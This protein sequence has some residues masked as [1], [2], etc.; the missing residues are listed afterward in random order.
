MRAVFAG[1]GTA[2]HVEPALATA[3]ALARAV[4]DAQITMVGT[5]R[6]LET[7]LVPERGYEL[8]L[9]PPVPMPR[10][11]T[12]DLLRLPLRMRAAV[13]ATVEILRHRRADVVVG[14]GGYVALPAYL[15]ARKL[16][17]PIVIHEANARPGL[18]NRIGARF[19]SHVA[20][21]PSAAPR[22]NQAEVVGIPLRTSISRLDR[23]ASRSEAMDHF[24]LDPGRVTL[25]VFGGSQG[26][27]RLNDGIAGAL[28]ALLDS[29]TQV[30]H[31]VGPAH[32][33]SDGQD[34]AERDGYHRL[35]YID[36]MD[37][38]YA[39]ADLV[40]SRAGAITCAE[41]SAV[42]LPAI[43]VP[44]PHGNGEQRF[45]ALPA[46]E[47]GGG[48]L[49]AD[50]SFTPEWVIEN[51]ASLLRN[52]Q[53][54]AEMGSAAATLGHRDA[55]DR[56]AEMIRRAAHGTEK[57]HRPSYGSGEQGERGGS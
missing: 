49:V 34:D 46:V 4:P 47:A 29:R 44:L 2:G 36:R 43:Y 40:V 33:D 15:A 56:L 23:Q 35:P 8:D 48:H 20:A 17:L 19:T 27:R 7:R 37:L 26:A 28:D 10:R 38:A 22:M 11:P 42:G 13:A 14:F 5:E 32:A 54:L 51:V 50:D 24:H 25:L 18:A 3:D 39:A 30:L 53:R 31:A 21:A 1:G 52:S 6:G 45:N 57:T 55:D 12:P 41:V 9:I 16:G